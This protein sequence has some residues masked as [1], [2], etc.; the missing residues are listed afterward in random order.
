MRTQSVISPNLEKY[1]LIESAVVVSLR[2]PTKS[3]QTSL[4]STWQAQGH[5]LDGFKTSH[6]ASTDLLQWHLTLRWLNSSHEGRTGTSVIWLK[7]SHVASTWTQVRW[8]MSSH[9]ASIRTHVR[10]LMFSHIVKKIHLYLLLF[11]LATL[12][13][14]SSMDTLIITTNCY[15]VSVDL[16]T[17]VY[18]FGDSGHI[19]YC[20]QLVLCNATLYLYIYF[21]N[22]HL[23]QYFVASIFIWCDNKLYLRTY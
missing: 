14:I 9:V 8:F 18:L 17:K 1:S 5:L 20:C 10:W 6:L 21:R 22:Y 12:I 3:F 4:L 13:F 7:S 16:R 15:F 11:H 2:P 23:E 19:Q